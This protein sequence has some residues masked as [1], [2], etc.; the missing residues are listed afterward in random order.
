MVLFFFIVAFIAKNLRIAILLSNVIIFLLTYFSIVGI[1]RLTSGQENKNLFRV[2]A[3]LFLILAS[4]TGFLLPFFNSH[5][6]STFMMCLVNT[7]LILKL[8][9]TPKFIYYFLLAIF[10]FLT[11]FSDLLFLVTFTAPAVVGLLALIL[12]AENSKHN[13]LIIICIILC[14]SGLLG[15]FANLYDLFHFHIKHQP[16]HIHIFHVWPAF[17]DKGPITLYEEHPVYLLIDVTYI[18]LILSVLF[19]VYCYKR[20]EKLE[21]Y[22]FLSLNNSVLFALII[23]LFCCLSSVFAVVYFDTDLLPP[24]AYTQ[25]HLIPA[26]L[27]PVFLGLP[28]LLAQYSNI[29]IALNRCYEIVPIAI[30][31]NFFIVIQKY[32]LNYFIKYYPPIT[33]CLDNY[34][35]KG[36]LTSKNGA[37]NY[38]DAHF[39][40]VLTKE[41][42]HIVAVLPDVKAFNWM[43]SRLDYLNREFNFV[44]IRDKYDHDLISINGAQVLKNLG[45][46]SSVLTCPGQYTIYVYKKGFKIPEG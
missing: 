5:F 8:F 9:E 43:S 11:N 31:L 14:L 17:R 39:N 21:H 46:P 4:Y 36:Y 12:L 37:S 35:R 2:S 26:M 38:W 29:G 19:N 32:S 30:I 44:I 27:L 41:N 7:Y 24:G 6:A 10:C 45:K 13:F 18:I 40:D 20:S 1:G 42:L 23:I 34:S 28:I 3:L 15:Y 33:Q 16:I 25:L 22:N